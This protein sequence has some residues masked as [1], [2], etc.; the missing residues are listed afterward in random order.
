M[1]RYLEDIDHEFLQDYKPDIQDKKLMS[2]FRKLMNRIKKLDL[3]SLDYNRNT[4]NNYDEISW[5]TGTLM[6]CQDLGNLSV[7]YR[8]NREDFPVYIDFSYDPSPYDMMDNLEGL[9]KLKAAVNDFNTQYIKLGDE[10]EKYSQE[11]DKYMANKAISRQ[12]GNIDDT[13][14]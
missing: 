11:L 6:L 10:Y 2:A 14:I 5:Y 4:P 13:D 8:H 12:K 7:K 1:I 3:P 9:A